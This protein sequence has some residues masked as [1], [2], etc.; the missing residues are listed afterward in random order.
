MASQPAIQVI[1]LEEDAL[2]LD[3]ERPE[4]AL[5]IRVVVGIK[6]IEGGDRAQDGQL[7]LRSEAMIPRVITSMPPVRER[8]SWSFKSRMWET[9]TRSF[10]GSP[11][12]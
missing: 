7:A 11:M 10:M 12:S 3:R 5:A 2:A 8:R 9:S 6:G 1:N 4:V